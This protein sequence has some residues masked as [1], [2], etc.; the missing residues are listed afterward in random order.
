MTFYFSFAAFIVPAMTGTISAISSFGILVI[1]WR[2]GVN[3][4]YHRIIGVMSVS[5]ILSSTAT[6]MATLAM[7]SDTIF[8][9][10]GPTIGTQ[11]TCTAQ[12]VSIFL[13]LGMTLNM[14]VALNVYYLCTLRYRM[15]A[16]S[17]RRMVE[18]L[19]YVVSLLL[20]I[21]F[22]V[23][24][25]KEDLINPTP[26]S[27][28]CSLGTRCE[29][30]DSRN[31][32]C[33]YYSEDEKETDK[34]VRRIGIITKWCGGTAL[35][36]LIGS[37]LLIILSFYKIERSSSYAASHSR[38]RTRGTS[39][40][41]PS[42]TPPSRRNELPNNTGQIE[43]FNG[44]LEQRRNHLDLTRSITK[45]AIIYLL[46]FLVTWIFQFLSFNYESYLINLL[47]VI[48]QPLQGFYN[49]SIFLYHKCCYAKKKF[50]EITWRQ[51]LV[52]SINDPS[53]VSVQI[54]ISRIGLLEES[55]FDLEA[56]DHGGDD[57]VEDE[58][59]ESSS[60]PSFVTSGRP[61]Q[62]DGSSHI[63]SSKV[64]DVEEWGIDNATSCQIRS[65]QTSGVWSAATV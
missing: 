20:A 3:S 46:A 13:G 33:N 10:K 27:S 21:W 62:E 40:L 35:F 50:P 2:S 9:F 1:I 44:D 54:V 4:I 31:G 30:F 36:F 15:S 41:V 23:Q 63:G 38:A 57:D 22:P 6:A 17:F 39:T 42:T 11:G 16:R 28:F 60:Q 64:I 32:D 52:I 8:P 25:S 58:D 18:P 48:F 37:M 49:I 65:K 14:N 45:Q 29:S 59:L 55:R 47:R 61:C 34:I 53:A 26:Y 51:A 5:D 56:Y 43:E 12:G 24:I 7:P 19:I